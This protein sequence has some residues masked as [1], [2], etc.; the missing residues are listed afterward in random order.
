MASALCSMMG[1]S[2]AGLHP[3]AG[4]GTGWDAGRREARE[5]RPGVSEWAWAML[6]PTASGSAVLAAA[7]TC[8]TAVVW[9]IPN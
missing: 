3:H 4:Q 9:V 7:G 6:V 2:S 1:S 5:G 8:C